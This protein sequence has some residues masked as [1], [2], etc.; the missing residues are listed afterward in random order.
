MF[1]YLLVL[2][3]SVTYYYSIIC[4]A[5]LLLINIGTLEEIDASFYH[6][7]IVPNEIDFQRVSV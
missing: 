2:K 3:G 4:C 1:L 6:Y 5:L 7:K